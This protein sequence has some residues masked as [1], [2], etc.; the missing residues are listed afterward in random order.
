MRTLLLLAL[1]AC[2]PPSPESQTDVT[3]VHERTRSESAVILDVRTPQEFA[4]GHI[5]GARNIPVQE[6]ASRLDELESLR[7]GPIDVICHSGGRSQTATNLLRE[8]GFQARNVSGG[9]L[10]WKAASLPV[11]T[12]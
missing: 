12:P 6:L 11:E 3:A 10:A 1:I 4:T 2:T 5:R 8:K 7:E 9:M